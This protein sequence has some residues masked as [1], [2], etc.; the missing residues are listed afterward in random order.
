LSNDDTPRREFA[1]VDYDPFAGA[2]LA[3]AVPTTEPQREVWLADRLGREASLA[4]NESICLSLTGALNVAALRGALQDLAQR[5]E[6]LRAHLSANGEE[7]LIAAE[8]KPELVITEHGNLSGVG[9][10]AALDLAK[11]RAVE[12]PFDLERGPLLRAE[13]LRLGPAD[14]VLILTA[15]H[16]ICDGWSFGIIVKELGRLYGARCGS[17]QNPL[18]PSPSFGSYALERSESASGAEAQ[19]AAAFWTRQFAGPLPVLDLP[20]DRPRAAWRT[21]RSRREDYLLDAELVA[22]ARKLG[23]RSGASLFSTL[24]SGFAAVLH[25]V[26]GAQDLV[27]GVPSAGQSGGMEGLVGHCVSLLPVRISI[28]PATPF[29]EA[30]AAAQTAVLDAAEHKECT[31]GTL[32]QRLAVSRDPSRLPLVSVM[33][34]VDQAL[35]GK[36]AGFTGLDV[37]IAS[38]PRS[39]ENFELFVNA[40]QVDGALR[41]EC[42][43]NADLFDG[44]T[45]RRW[46]TCYETILRAACAS[47]P[48]AIGD[49]ELVTGAERAQLD[50]WNR[51]ARPFSRT[52]LVHELIEAQTSRA[53]GRAALRWQGHILS[54]A[55]LEARANRIARSLRARG[56]RSGSRVGLHLERS[57]DMLAALLGVLKAGAAY[58]P[59]DPSYPVDRLNF[60]A[61]DAGLSVLVTEAS[62]NTLLAWPRERTLLLDGDQREIAAQSDVR[63]P[64]DENS[65]GPEG[66]AYVIYTSGTTG[67]PKGVQVPHLAVVNFL[68]SM[69]WEPG[70]TE[71]ERL[72]AVTT[73]SFDIAVTELLLPLTVGAE[74]VL[75]SREDAVDGERLARL[76]RDSQATSMQATPSTWRLLIGAGWQGGP[77]FK[78]LCG[79]EALSADLARQLLERTGSLW[80]MYGPT[81]TTV[82]SSCGRVE[83]GFTSIS[84][85]RP[86]ANTS[87][88]ILDPQSRL[89]PTGV[90]GEIVI[91][92]AG[93]A[94]GYLNLPQLTAERFIP[95]PYSDQPG[96]RLY[97]T[98]DRGRW[99]A[100]GSLEHL[101][102][103]DTQVK[104]RGYRIEL[105][106][107]ELGLAAHPDVMQAAVLAREDRPGDVRLVAYVVPRPGATVAA[108][109]LKSHLKLTL[110][111]Y[112]IPQHFVSLA[113]LPLLPNGK[114]D[115]KALPLPEAPVRGNLEYVAPRTDL[116]RAVAAQME[117]SLGMSGIGAHD[118]F[119]ALGGHSLLAAQLTYRLNESLGTRISMR[120]LFESPTVARLAEA[121]QAELAQGAA[122]NRP[123]I[124][125]L[126]DQSRMPTS[127][128]QERMWFLEQMNPGRVVYH[129]PSAHRLL[130][131]LDERAFEAAFR[132]IVR[133]QASLRTSF[134]REGD[135][136]VQQVAE[137]VETAL[138]PAEDL[139][140]LP[141][142]ERE[143][144]LMQRLEELTAEP[145]DLS[146]APLF[147]ARLFRLGAQEHVLFFMAHHIV[148][149]GWS[150][151]L[152]YDE[153]AA[154]YEAYLERRPSP[155]PDPAISY[156]DF[157]AWH[158]RWVEGPEVAKQLGYW[159]EGLLGMGIPKPLP[160]DRP[161]RPG[162]SGIGN[163]EWIGIGRATTDALHELSSKSGATLF[164]TLLTVYGVL[165]YDYARQ[166]RLVVGTPVRGRESADLESVMGYFNN[167][168]PL[169]LNLD[170]GET[171]QDLVLRVKATVIESFNHP[172]V[173]LEMILR[174][175]PF[176]RS[177]AGSV[178]YQVLFSFQDARQRQT[179]WGN[180]QHKVVPLFQRGA[181]E[182]FGLWFVET[183]QGLQGG[184]TYNT[185]IITDE[186]A[187]WLHQRYLTIVS[188]LLEDPTA[189]VASLVGPAHPTRSWAVLDAAPAATAASVANT[190]VAPRTELEIALTTVWQRLL[191][192]AQVGITDN[193]FDLGG[194]SLTAIDLIL[195][196]E[197]VGGVKINLGEVF[198]N[199]T[200]AELVTTLG[201]DADRDASIV[202]PLQPEGDGIP[203]FCV[204]G[205]SIYKSFA[206][207][208]GKNQPVFGV[209]VPE[210]QALVDQSLEGKAPDVSIDR[211]AEAYDKAIARFRPKGPYRLAGLSFGG[212]MSMELASRMR[213]RGEEV[214]IVIL[215]DTM[216]MEGVHRKWLKLLTHPIASLKSGTARESL[217]SLAGRLHSHLPGA[218]A[219][220]EDE[221]RMTQLD[222]A[223]ALRR[224]ALF[225]A[226]K[227]WN[228]E[229]LIT[230][231][232]VM[233]LHGMDH[234]SW[235]P[236]I[237]F[238]DDYGWRRHLRGPFEVHHVAGN[239]E[240]IIESPY[241]EDLGGIVLSR[242]RSKPRER[243]ASD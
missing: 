82:W 106:E 171:F 122:A 35:D 190:Y 5:H 234:A 218:R 139:T 87:I 98:G 140:A 199:P 203:I 210:E 168:L 109:V 96:A 58:V 137:S 1:P 78:A 219:R 36:D 20:T 216:L 177:G 27:I 224:L 44:A 239:H 147:R 68:E 152:L 111:D 187:H 183:A 43:Y 125:H 209:Y 126:A 165:L 84:I 155:L 134:R 201:P 213:A 49:F 162:M 16:V 69:G 211:L 223:D 220:A 51:T 243:P 31:L 53:P 62:Q 235:G 50:A 10:E 163:T 141:P 73:L 52:A 110:P 48:V 8:F 6:S 47:A 80:N 30:I 231:F 75:A 54:Y 32:L 193:F 57:P 92:G 158:R 208:L 227:R 167:L 151:D 2:S 233:L 196:M 34:N 40:V 38:N 120:T 112:M 86:I 81:E 206:L 21:F 93:V 197:A 91:G 185:D 118:D 121:I 66:C 132:E 71:S 7:L 240:T 79:G 226:T 105:A 195:E 28:T 95:N 138:L 221:S 4:F 45:V 202:V 135:S 154:L 18:E 24:L 3:R 15:H 60:M 143:V 150:F 130:G 214:D 229:R 114:L 207:S 97:R 225:Q 160:T 67:K 104:V 184:V 90:P 145:F 33:F 217:R 175:L 129:A 232:R 117:R 29:Q 19:A 194:N 42:Q 113:G 89:C 142:Q 17:S 205:I 153:M 46:L 124:A 99:L 169:Q 238:D 61:A 65:P 189:T 119:F 156:G 191:G 164:V 242:M 37:R 9:R 241:V 70:M 103:L 159:R 127:L 182:D 41:L 23:G 102:R 108:S 107:I 72:V 26:S 198:R 55:T 56:V 236:H 166:T 77:R 131:R 64:R 25:R 178:L 83:A 212:I 228:A 76:L 85:G 116:E 179:Q 176:A 11:S 230:D 157:A 94:L 204:V 144:R 22:A 181:T 174:E 14:H 133:R 39:Y 222:R 172:D 186:T 12:T 100:N 237:T 146:R 188:Q 148:W 63:L 123:P 192:V 128:M 74:I 59:L 170:P 101:G 149:D 180:L 200:I 136:V 115:R 13:L 88:W 215:I 173:P 161:R